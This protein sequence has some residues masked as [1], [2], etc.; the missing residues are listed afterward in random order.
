MWYRYILVW[1]SNLSCRC[2]GIYLSGTVPV[3]VVQVYTCLV[4]YPVDVVQGIL[5]GTV[6]YPVDVVQGILVWYSN[7]SCRCGT[8]NTCLVQ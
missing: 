7:L 6:T 2:T 5:S 1:C 4:T 8:G 3:D